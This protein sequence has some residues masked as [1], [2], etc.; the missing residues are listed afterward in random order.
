MAKA[1]F[2]KVKAEL[3]DTQKPERKKFWRAMRNAWSRTAVA[4]GLRE[5]PKTERNPRR[6]AKANP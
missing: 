1:A 3:D 5:P 4:I 6:K 2:D